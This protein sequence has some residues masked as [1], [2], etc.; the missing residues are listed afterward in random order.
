MPIKVRPADLQRDRSLLTDLLS[1]FLNPDAGGRR[2]GWLYE[3]NPDGPAQA[4]IA[5]EEGTGK[6]VGA[7]AAFPRRFR[8][9]KSVRRGYVLGDFCIDAH[10]RSLGLALQLQRACLKHIE[11]T[12][13]TLGYDFP[14]ERMMAVYHRMQIAPSCRM[15]RWAKPLRA[16]RKIARFVKSPAFARIL[17][18]P[19]NKLLQWRDAAASAPQN[20][21][22]IAKHEG[23]CGE[24]FAQLAETVGAT[25]GTCIAR[26]PE[27]LNW[28]YGRHPLQH[29]EMLTVR[30]NDRLEGYI[31]FSH[32]D[33]D[34]SIVDFFGIHET[35]L[36]SALLARALEL[37]RGRRIETV[38]V[39]F[40][41]IHACTGLLKK[42]GFHPRESCP[43]VVYDPEKIV[44]FGEEKPSS[45]FI[46]DG[47]RDS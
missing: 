15:V 21:W 31:V 36:W 41:E 27:Y 42:F 12:S 16:D 38:S 11:A 46:M 37:L 30:R 34:A 4:W 26:S 17:A 32:A 23:D 1:R 25:Y 14:S 24:E 29:H 19:V 5:V 45:W 35:Q 20:A 28:R 40:E 18:A 9:G 22:T 44:T 47:D 39:S 3:E 6:A 8:V 7:A 33:A 10:H 13:G 2:F 43:V